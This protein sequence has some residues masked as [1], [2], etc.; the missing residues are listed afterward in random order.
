MGRRSTN[1]AKL[2]GYTIART[3]LTGANVAEF[4]N[5]VRTKATDAVN[6]LGH[7][8]DELDKAHQRLQVEAGD[9]DRLL[10]ARAMR[11]FAETL[12]KTANNVAVI[13]A[14]ATVTLPVALETAARIRNDA[15]RTA[16][17]C[18]AST[19]NW[20]SRSDQHRKNLV[21]PVIRPAPSS[22]D[23]VM[24]SPYRDVR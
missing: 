3:Y 9:D 4:A 18:A 14:M 23:C 10:V 7:L 15:P 8:C 16:E 17:A 11:K 19:G 12:S 24:R 13:D 6:E 2:F 1:A 22:N 21:S 20:P 5:Q